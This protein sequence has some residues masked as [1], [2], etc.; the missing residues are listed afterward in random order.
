VITAAHNVP[1]SR[2]EI[3]VRRVDGSEARAEVLAAGG[4]D[5]A[6]LRADVADLPV[7][8]FARLDRA[9]V[10]PVTGC[11]AIGYPRF[12]ETGSG[13]PPLR[14]IAQVDGVIPLASN[15]RRGLFE[16]RTTSTPRPLPTG[17]L[18]ASEWQGMSGAVVFAGD[19]AVGVVSEHHLPEG[20]SALTIV[21]LTGLT[22]IGAGTPWWRSLGLDDWTVIPGPVRTRHVALRRPL[23]DFTGRD[24]AIEE[25]S[26]LLTVSGTAP[27]V[28]LYG[29]AGVGKTT[30]ANQVAHRLTP[31]FPY[32]RIFVDAGDSVDAAMTQILHGFGLFGT[33]LPRDPHE[34]RH[35][36]QELLRAGPCLLVLDNA[37][38]AAQVLPLLPESPGSAVI[39]TSRSALTS[40]E[41]ADRVRLDPLPS[42]E[43]LRLFERIVGADVVARDRSAGGDIVALLGGLPLAIRITAADVASPAMRR[44]PL[45]FH[46]GR[47]ADEQRRMSYLTGEDRGVRSSFDLSYR[48]LGTDAARLFRSLGVLPGIDFTADL[49]ASATGADP[50]LLD[51]LADRQLIEVTG[52]YGTRYRLHDLIRLYARERAEQEDSA[53]SRAQVVRESVTWYARRLDAWMSEPGAHERP[54]DPALEWFAEEQLNVRASLGAAYQAEEWALLREMSG[55]LYGLLWYRGH[56]SELETVRA[57]GVEAARHENDAMAELGALIHL[58]E[59]RRALGRA[60]ETPELYERALAIARSAGDQDKEGWVL[61]HYGDLQCDLG[62]PHE[63]LD[64]YAEA[65]E[66]YRARDDAGARIWLAAHISDAYQGLDRP[67]D[68]VRVEEE[69]LSLSR[70]RGD[71][72]EV[73]WCQWHLALAYQQWGRLD[74]AERHL[75]DCV[76]HH[77]GTRDRAALATMLTALARVHRQAGHPD[78]ARTALTE[79][80]ELARAIDAPDRIAE[81]TALL[82]DR[83]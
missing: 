28:V 12:K 58:A 36:I 70:R 74:E 4:P 8:R 38:G 2:A 48:R 37:P 18:N 49:V 40:L 26:A 69:A 29:M 39:V 75:R 53:A 25:L 60:A 43:G 41:G 52:P 1:D 83:E 21:P 79:A 32:A 23:A 62:R 13:S 72:A 81:I 16:L 80:L 27:V 64:R 67:E 15:L 22:E 7:I 56:W 44:R 31:A 55:S 59:A 54:P 33:D 65:A 20:P 78:Q 76:T 46:A 14:D 68:A 5:L 50:A 19:L 3:L 82:D 24:E 35:R 11:W 47:L 6:V 71:P 66:I 51:E 77:R 73:T 45:A 10:G 61:T 17:P 57:W 30:L 42:S 63:A 34:R 9:Q